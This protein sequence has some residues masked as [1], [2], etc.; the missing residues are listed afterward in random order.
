MLWPRFQTDSNLGGTEKL[1]VCL[2]V[3]GMMRS[4]P[5]IKAQEI[6]EKEDADL[7]VMPMNILFVKGWTR[8]LAALS[9]MAACFE[10]DELL[11]AWQWQSRHV[12]GIFGS[13]VKTSCFLQLLRDEVR[14]SGPERLPF[15]G[16]KYL[17]HRTSS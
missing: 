10:N 2:P 1:T 6:C 4:R 14:E 3:S 8:S 15:L 5:L 12:L 17:T 11:K 9:I 16:P 7:M 13:S